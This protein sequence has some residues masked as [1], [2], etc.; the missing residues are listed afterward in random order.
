[1]L[2][3]EHPCEPLKRPSPIVGTCFGSSAQRTSPGSA[4]GCDFSD[5][6]RRSFKRV[7]AKAGDNKEV[8]TAQLLAT[9]KLI[10]CRCMTQN[11][12]KLE[13]QANTVPSLMEPQG[14]WEV[15]PPTKRARDGSRVVDE[16][17]TF[18]GC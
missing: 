8:G 11:S 12:M 2:H 15:T 9:R 4:V 1:M 16:A 7:A 6:L 3:P 17:G 13:T 14:C 5:G 18:A 10:P